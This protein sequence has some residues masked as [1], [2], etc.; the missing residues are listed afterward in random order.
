M[1]LLF[2]VYHDSINLV[3]VGELFSDEAE[4]EVL[5][6]FVRNTARYD[7]VAPIP[8]APNSFHKK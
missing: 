1:E 4:Q 2:Y 5:P 7:P 3:W 6:Q 8:N